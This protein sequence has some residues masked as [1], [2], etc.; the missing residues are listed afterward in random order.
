[1]NT[2]AH[3]ILNLTLLGRTVP[4]PLQLA[5]VA[6]ALIPDAPMVLFYA[7]QKLVLQTP[8]D[9]IWGQK[10]QAAHWQDFFDVFN[11][12]PFMVVGLIAGFATRSKVLML[13]FGSM[14]LHVAGDLPL[15][16]DDAHRHFFPLS[17][18]RFESPVSYWDVNHYGNVVSLLEGG[19]VVI[20]CLVLWFT[21]RRWQ[22]RVLPAVLATIYLGYLGYV[23]L[24]WA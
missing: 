8:E 10:Y 20:A 4:W 17:D 13:L 21:H 1:M 18:W 2:P 14:L 6:G 16:H 9:V 22:E 5:I 3:A 19:F 15:H 23:M 7:Y 12:V 11:S 24:V